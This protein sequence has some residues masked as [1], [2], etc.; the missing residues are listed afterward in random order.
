LLGSPDDPDNGCLNGFPVGYFAPTYKNMREVWD[1]FIDIYHPLIS[2][3][4]VAEKRI[5]LYGGGI[6]DFWSLDKPNTVRGRK[7]KRV[8]VDE[9]AII[10]DLKNTWIKILR[11]MLADLIGDAWFLS[12]PKGKLNYFHD[13][14]KIATSQPERWVSHQLPTSNNPHISLEEIEDMKLELDP[15]SYAQEILASFVTE[16]LSSWA[17]C[18]DP[19]K[20]VGSTH[21]DKKHDVYLSFDFNKNPITCFVAQHHAGIRGIQQ[22][23]LP[24]SDIYQLCDYIR[25]NYEGCMFMVTG[26]ATGNHSTAMVKDNLNYYVII[27]EE[28]RLASPQ[29]RVPTINPSMKE[30]RVQVNAVLH[31]RDVKLDPI[32]CK[33]LLFDLEYAQVLPNGDLDKT[34]RKDPTKQLDALDCFRY[35]LNTFH[36]RAIRG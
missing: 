2:V 28:L 26:D 36:K 1:E 30:N 34:D 17:Y 25:A 23:K 15:I 19:L 22:I 24:T 11:P 18:Y 20:H 31:N 32:A 14:F 9:A 27:K 16:N 13:L 21:L 7:Y 33:G 4:N 6:C 5:E 29:I 8:V 35:Y 3:R 12:T 10:P